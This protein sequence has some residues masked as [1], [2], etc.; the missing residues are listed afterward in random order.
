[1]V[2]HFPQAFP[3]RSD[4]RSA[5]GL[6]LG[7]PLVAGCA[8]GMQSP[9]PGGEQPAGPPQQPTAV[10]SGQVK[11]GLLLPLSAAGNAGAAAQSMRNAAELALTEFQNPNIQ[12]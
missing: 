7:A 12:L 6:I 4:C 9:F 2:A 10:G 8:G 3:Q 11:V 1:M 5:I